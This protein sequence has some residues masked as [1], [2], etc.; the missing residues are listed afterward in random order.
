MPQSFR[1]NARLQ[2]RSSRTAWFGAAFVVATM[3][4]SAALGFE[5]ESPDLKPNQMMPERYV[6]GGMGC[7]GDNLSPALSWRDAPEGTKSFA[8][9]VHDP[10]APTGGAGIWHWVVINIP[11]G[12][13]AIEAGASTPD[14]SK[15]PPGSRQ[16][17]N[18]YVGMTG[19]FAWSGPCPPKGAEP[20]IYNFTLYAL[21][22]E[23][24]DPPPAATASQVGF[25]VNLNA[26]GKAK[27]SVRYG[28]E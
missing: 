10:D 24:L 13:S 25:L 23:K 5:L 9:M 8:I 1:N 16:I 26:L 4:A 7:K 12:T 2:A 14:G 21:K 20:H 18:D 11:A 28:R 19:N 6:F 17:A 27:L 3:T 15:L 22:I